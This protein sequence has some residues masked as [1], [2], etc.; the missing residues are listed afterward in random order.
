M[1]AWSASICALALSIAARSASTDC[2]DAA[3][4][5]ANNP[6]QEAAVKHL[7]VKAETELGDA[8]DA[9]HLATRYN[10]KAIRQLR[11]FD[12]SKIDELRKQIE[13]KHKLNGVRDASKP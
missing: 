11:E 1:F 2:S 7:I 13:E 10:K 3:A 6:R 5:E 8:R 12:K 9:H 4:V